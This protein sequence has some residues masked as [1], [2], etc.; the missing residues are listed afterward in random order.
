MGS[1]DNLG[2]N[3]P[4]DIGSFKIMNIEE[5]EKNLNNIKNTNEENEVEFNEEEW[6]EGATNVDKTEKIITESDGTK[7]ILEKKIITFSDG[8]VKTEVKKKYMYINYLLIIFKKYYFIF[9]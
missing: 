7:V 5:N 1:E 9:I 2:N 3:I 6:P 4:Y 8:T